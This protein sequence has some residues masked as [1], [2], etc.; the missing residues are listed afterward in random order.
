MISS[1]FV[2]RDTIKF[3]TCEKSGEEVNLV[4]T[5]DIVWPKRKTLKVKVLGSNFEEEVPMLRD[6]CTSTIRFVSGWKIDVNSLL[7]ATDMAPLNLADFFRL[8]DLP[9]PTEYQNER[10]CYVLGVDGAIG[11][12]DVM[13]SFQTESGPI[14]RY[15]KGAPS[16]PKVGDHVSCHERPFMGKT[17]TIKAIERDGHRLV[18]ND[19]EDDEDDVLDVLDCSLIGRAMEQASPVKPAEYASTWSADWSKTPQVG[20]KVTEDGNDE[21]FQVSSII[22]H[23]LV[24]KS[25]RFMDDDTYRL[26]PAKCRLITRL[27]FVPV[28]EKKAEPVNPAEYGAVLSEEWSRVPK[29][30]DRVIEKI[31]KDGDPES[32][33]AESFKVDSIENNGHKLVCKSNRFMDENHYWLGT[34][35]CTLIGCERPYVPAMKKVFLVVSQKRRDVGS[36]TPVDDETIGFFDNEEEAKTTCTSFVRTDRNPRYPI[37]YPKF[38]GPDDR[39]YELSTCQLPKGMITFG[40]IENEGSIRA[41]ALAKLT[42]KEKKVLGLVEKK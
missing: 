27:G 19:G 22:G 35:K 5:I 1:R 16:F 7:N 34:S 25:N 28:P 20:D 2:N 42:D 24:C 37:A 13:V 23:I 41:A 15:G 32:F 40:P 21:L 12:P 11:S 38:L 3:F 31:V 29:V 33:K 39:L 26:E 8:F 10:M 30:G 17:F 14:P 18:C 4:A 9:V 36:P 6:V